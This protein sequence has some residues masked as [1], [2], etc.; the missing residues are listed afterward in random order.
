MQT[1]LSCEKSVSRLFQRIGI[2]IYCVSSIRRRGSYFWKARRYQRQIQ[3]VQVIQLRSN[4]RRWADTPLLCNATTDR[5]GQQYVQPLSP[6]ISGGNKSENTNRPSA[7]SVTGGSNYLHTCFCAAYSSRGYYSAACIYLRASDSA[8][9][10]NCCFNIQFL[11]S[12]SN[13]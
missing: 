11:I 12:N 9:K 6:A 7:N 5:R 8:T 13:M 3:Y 10:T 4:S 1:I 2:A